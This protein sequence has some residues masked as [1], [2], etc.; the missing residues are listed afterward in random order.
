MT[1]TPA[2][3]QSRA[4]RPHDPQM[5]LSSLRFQ[6]ARNWRNFCPGCPRQGE[7]GPFLSP[8]SPRHPWATCL[9]IPE[10]RGATQ[11]RPWA[12]RSVHHRTGAGNAICCP[13]PRLLCC[14]AHVPEPYLLA[15]HLCRKAPRG[16]PVPSFS[17]LGLGFS[18]ASVCLQEHS[19]LARTAGLRRWP[20]ACPR[21]MP[22]PRQAQQV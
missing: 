10:T 12:W 9:P 14:C 7:T 5:K 21:G 19:G 4:P 3:L 20:M 8:S 6:C 13:T 22:E 11:D 1:A 16:L 18:A 2:Q 15:H 17:V